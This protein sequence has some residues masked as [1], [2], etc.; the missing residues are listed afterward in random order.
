MIVF[1]ALIHNYSSH[2]GSDPKADSFG[3]QQ[4]G[5]EISNLKRGRISFFYSEKLLVPG[6]LA[7]SYVFSSV[8]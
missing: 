3:N 6:H 8:P 2:L 7:S 1:A 5:S 4:L